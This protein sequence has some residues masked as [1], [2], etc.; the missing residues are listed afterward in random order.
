MISAGTWLPVSDSA[1]PTR[2]RP[3]HLTFMEQLF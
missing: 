1:E 3:A 2:P